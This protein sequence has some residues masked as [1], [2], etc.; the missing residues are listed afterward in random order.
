MK[1]RQGLPLIIA[2]LLPVLAWA[3][4]SGSPLDE[5]VLEIPSLE[6]ELGQSP[7]A[8]APAEPPSL[9]LPPEMPD[10]DFELIPPAPKEPKAPQAPMN[11]IPPAPPPPVVETEEQR[12]AKTATLKGLDKITARISTFEAA[13][14]Q[15]ARFGSLSIVVRDCHKRP[16]EETPETSA[17]LE[18]TD[19]GPEQSWKPR[20]IA[21]DMKKLP[22]PEN[23]VA[24]QG[25]MVFSGWMFASSP[26]LSALE[27]PIYDISVTDCATSA[28]ETSS[29]SE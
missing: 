8:G 17:F 12:L 6:E 24:K 4:G 1:M 11:F 19:M 18:I 7:E 28:P 5:P 13:I 3:Q 23:A 29:G 26:A 2:V 27:H 16:A 25:Q 10:E 9:E 21:A 15:P 14:D 20:D 22:A